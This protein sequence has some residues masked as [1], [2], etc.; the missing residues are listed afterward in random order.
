MK[1]KIVII[2]NDIDKYIN[3]PL[4]WEIEEK[5][6]KPEFFSDPEKGLRYISEH[7]EL[8]HIVLLD[9]D[10]PK[11]QKNGHDV[12]KSINEM[13]KLIPV[14][15]WSG[16]D[17]NKEPFIDLIN[18]NAFA[19]LSKSTTSA[20]AMKV[21]SSAVDFLKSSLSNVIEDWIIKKDVDKN[22][23]VYITSDG[24]SYSLNEILIEIRQQTEVGLSF[25]KNLN[26][27]TIDLLLRGKERLNG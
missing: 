15:L 26:A 19:F 13:S 12:L 17:E 25:S 10:F 21:I 18:N 14:I 20:E 16:V 23:P 7:L 24:R 1:V 6:D 4:V 22:K 11:G 3:D 9:I 5:Y 2:E 27:L 8:N